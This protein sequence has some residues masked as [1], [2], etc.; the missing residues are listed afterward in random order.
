M[1]G[2]GHGAGQ[3]ADQRV[4]DN[5]QRF[6]PQSSSQQTS[7]HLDTTLPS[8]NHL[9]TFISIPALMAHCI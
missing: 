3:I 2:M 8:L 5:R 9:C 4:L 6:I 7:G 1:T